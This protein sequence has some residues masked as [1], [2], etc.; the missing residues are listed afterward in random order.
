[1]IMEIKENNDEYI[2]L[3]QEREFIKTNEH[4]YKIGKTKQEC[5]KRICNY[6]NG[7]KL[8]IQ[9][10]CNDCDKYEKILINK[11]KEIFIHKKD[12]GYEYFKG[13]YNQMINI[14][15]NTVYELDIKKGIENEDD[16]KTIIENQ[17]KKCKKILSSNNYLQKHLLICNGISN[18]LECHLCHKILCDSS[19]KSKHLKICKGKTNNNEDKTNEDKTNEDKTNK[20]KTN[21]DKT[22]EDKNNEDKTN[23]DNLVI[24]DNENMKI[25]FDISHINDEEI[26]YKLSTLD[27]C[28]TFEYF[29]NKLFENKNNQMIVKTNL[30]HYYSIV[31]MGNNIWKKHTDNLIYP[32]VILEITKLILQYIDDKA[33]LKEYLKNI[34]TNKKY[35]NMLKLLT[36]SFSKK[37]IK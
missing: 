17:C 9:I 13:N 10:I 35:C 26:S 7:T 24:F 15:Y 27:N 25:D 37:N 12:I 20:D 16:E 14:I 6:P 19:S 29:C 5:L 8:L 11:F 2:Y 3:L 18:P 31:Y 4:I 22:N 36:N 33:E 32:I 23:E 30:K 28:Y 34:S 1:M 21:E